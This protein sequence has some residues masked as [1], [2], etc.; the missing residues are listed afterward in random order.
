[1]WPEVLSPVLTILPR[2]LRAWHLARERRIIRTSR[3]QLEE[4]RSPVNRG[5]HG[6]SVRSSTEAVCGSSIESSSKLCRHPRGSG[7]DRPARPRYG[8]R[9]C[10]QVAAGRGVCV[11]H[12][13][14]PLSA[15]GLMRLCQ[16]TEEQKSS[17]MP[18]ATYAER[19]IRLLAVRPTL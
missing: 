10:A 19:R 3:K 15:E 11:Q 14:N 7:I 12:G 5:L 17:E 18:P 9:R 2:Q 1:M 4:L 8:R 13:R 6:G 16:K